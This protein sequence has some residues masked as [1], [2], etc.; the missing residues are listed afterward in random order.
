MNVEPAYLRRLHTDLRNARGQR[1]LCLVLIV[2][3]LCR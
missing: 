2:I 3:L 1:N